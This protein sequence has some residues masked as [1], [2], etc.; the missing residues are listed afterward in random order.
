MKTILCLLLILISNGAFAQSYQSQMDSL[1]K[2]KNV[3]TE[4]TKLS[5]LFYQGMTTVVF[6]PWMGTPWDFN[7]TS[8]VPGEGEIA[9]G[10]FVSTTLKH[11]GFNLNRYRTAQ[12][13]ASVIID[14]L[15]PK[16]QLRFTDSKTLV[17]ELIQKGNDK[18]YIV[19]LD[20]H[21]GYLMV[22]NNQVYFVHSDF[23]NSKVLKELALESKG[24]HATNNYVLGELT[25][26]AEL[27]KKWKNNTR[28]Y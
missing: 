6:P 28:I 4:N 22:E 8:N 5:H 26:N 21:V 9:C 16:N 1:V 10:Y 12:Q 11:F 25:N 23:F 19:G 7:G 15:C 3:T 2:L 27:M 17:D 13:A 20:Y 14:I 18:L 24:F